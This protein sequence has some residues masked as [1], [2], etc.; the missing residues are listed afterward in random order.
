I[1]KRVKGTPPPVPEGADAVAPGWG[2]QVWPCLG[3]GKQKPKEPDGR[4]ERESLGLGVADG[5]GVATL[6]PHSEGKPRSPGIGA[7]GYFSFEGSALG[8]LMLP[9]EPHWLLTTRSSKVLA[10]A[11]HVFGRPCSLTN[12]TRSRQ[13]LVHESSACGAVPSRKG[14][15]IVRPQDLL[16][17]SP[18][19]RQTEVMFTPLGCGKSV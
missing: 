14:T 7:I 5:C 6:V 10:A 15:V 12:L 4:G 18:V 1:A 16:G 17:A 3:G 19:H 9:D 2:G 8:S 13:P 11:A